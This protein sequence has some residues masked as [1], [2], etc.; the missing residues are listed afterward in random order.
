[1]TCFLAD[2]IL[3]KGK[4]CL[5]QARWSVGRCVHVAIAPQL[6]I[7]VLM[8]SVARDSIF[9]YKVDFSYCYFICGSFACARAVQEVLQFAT[10]G[11]RD[12]KTIQGTCSQS[13][14]DH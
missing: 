8:S 5:I 3:K 1:M 13:P 10:H 9:G 7:A 11:Q 4:V 6:L 2:K 14:S 12:M